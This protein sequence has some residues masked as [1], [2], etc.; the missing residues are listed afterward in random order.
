MIASQ[1]RGWCYVAHLPKSVAELMNDA[2]TLRRIAVV[3]QV[4][5]IALATWGLSHGLGWTLAPALSMAL[6]I[7]VAVFIL[8]VGIAFIISYHGLGLLANTRPRMPAHPELGASLS[9]SMATT[10]LLS[11]CWAVWRLFNVI[12]PFCATWAW[13]PASGERRELPPLLLIHGYGC[14]QAVWYDAQPVLAAAGY[15]CEGIDLLPLFGDIDHYA[16]QIFTHCLRMR[17]EYGRAPVLIGH[18]MG[19]LSARAA[20]DYARASGED[21]VIEHVITLGS[22]H[23]G[24][25]LAKYGQGRNAQQMRC[26][27][28]WLAAL[29]ARESVAERAHITS[30]FSLHDSIVGPPG[31]AW[32]DGARHRILAGLGHVALLNDQRAHQAI[33]DALANIPKVQSHVPSPQRKA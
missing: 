25:A 2:T 31:T 26:G 11:E 27:G 21:T 13:H 23:Q 7:Y 29:A 6:L 8:L 14:N 20:L 30:I 22:P 24:T 9:W 17:S 12:Q 32:L 1:V 19:G 3:C 16:Q 10:C 5:A 4:L 33:L 28:D 15:R 18:S